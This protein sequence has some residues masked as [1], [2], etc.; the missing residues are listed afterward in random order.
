MMR[1]LTL[2]KPIVSY[3]M[4]CLEI[5]GCLFNTVNIC[6]LQSTNPFI[7]PI[8]TQQNVRCTDVCRNHKLNIEINQ[9]IACK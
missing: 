7:L 6:L 9:W 1:Q 4:D 3:L 8:L 2:F 5:V